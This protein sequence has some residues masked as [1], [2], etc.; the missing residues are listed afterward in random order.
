MVMEMRDRTKQNGQTRN[1]SLP[2][3]SELEMLGA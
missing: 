3:C 1:L 2:A